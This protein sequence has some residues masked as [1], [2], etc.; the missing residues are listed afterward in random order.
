MIETS[1]LAVVVLVALYFI[2]LGTCSLLAPAVARRFLLGFAGSAAAHYTELLVR[3]VAG[4][5]ILVHAPK[6]PFA[7]AFNVLGWVLLVTTIALFLVPW[8][9]HHRFARRMVPKALPYLALIGFCSLGIGAL[10]LA[11]VVRGT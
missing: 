6:L 5:A 1:A 11:A 8:Q 7:D 2:A 3:L 4:A 9:W 10:V